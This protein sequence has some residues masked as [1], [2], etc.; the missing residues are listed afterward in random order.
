M[1]I[2]D[3]NIRS[4]QREQLRRYR[5]VARQIGYDIAQKGIQDQAII[6]FLHQLQ[7]PTFVTRDRDFYN[8]RL[9]HQ[10]YCL[11]WLDVGRDQ[12][13]EYIR[14]VLRHP[15]LNAQTKRMGA[16]IRVSS[17]GLRILRRHDEEEAMSW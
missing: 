5:L 16:V 12:V 4:D 3:E 11:V 7:R 1:N 13:A 15:R 9:C 8:R 17:A 14:R 10:G 2:L 6:P